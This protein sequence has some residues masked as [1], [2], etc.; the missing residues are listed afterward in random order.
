MTIAC[1]IYGQ[2]EVEVIDST[3]TSTQYLIGKSTLKSIGIYLSSD[4][5]STSYG[6]SSTPMSNLS[7]NVLFNKRF[8]LGAVLGRQLNRSYTPLGISSTGAIRSN[9][10]MVGV[11]LGYNFSP[12][13]LINFTLPIQIGIGAMQVDSVT[14][15]NNYDIYHGHHGRNYRWGSGSDATF[16]FISPGLEVNLNVF[17]YGV[18]YIGS[19]YRFATNVSNDANID[20]VVIQSDISGLSFVAGVKLGIFDMWHRKVK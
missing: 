3:D 2:N 7:V 11:K 19:Y 18:F 15:L 1:S 6:G 9:M 16:G 12:R 20:Y 17:K 8:F 4:I 10:D 14:K 5:G 13:K